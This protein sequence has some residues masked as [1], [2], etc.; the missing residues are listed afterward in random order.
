MR[1]RHPHPDQAALPFG[2]KPPPYADL[3]DDAPHELRKLQHV[4]E[5]SREG[6]RKALNQAMLGLVV[7]APETIDRSIELL[8]AMDE[9]DPL[10]LARRLD[11]LHIPAANPHVPGIARFA[12]LEVHRALKK[13]GPEAEWPNLLL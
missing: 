13:V 5:S 12:L 1:R 8:R 3:S 9:L 2:P 10:T 4:V 6:I 7:D 11:E